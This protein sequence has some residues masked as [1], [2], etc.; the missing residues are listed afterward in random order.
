MRL[1]FV[2]DVMLGRL[3]NDVLKREPP[4]YPWGDTLELFHAADWRICNLECVLSD[5]GAPWSQTSKVFHF[6]SDAKNVASLTA[7]KINVASIANNHVLD[8]EYEAMIEMLSVLDQANIR[9]AGAGK[10]LEEAM[11]PA[12]T[13]VGGITI[14]ALACTDNEPAWA[15]TETTPGVFYAPIDLAHASTRRLMKRVQETKRRVGILILSIH[16]GPNWGYRPQPRHRPFAHALVDAGADVVFG[17]SCHVF[18]GIEVYRGRPILYSTGD[19]VDDYAVDEIERN[20]ESFTLTLDVENNEL[21]QLTLYPTVIREFHAQRARRQLGRS[22]ASTME[23]LCGEFGT[24]TTWD[25]RE[26]TL[27]VPLAR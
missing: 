9:H 4:G 13:E 11:A 16:W 15:A 7:A 20:D 5:R 21:Q 24:M 10:N 1:L 17:H 25:A 6:R 27:T 23:T 19:F 12:I 8:Y 14:G 22:I 18:Q 2:G 3:V 26:G